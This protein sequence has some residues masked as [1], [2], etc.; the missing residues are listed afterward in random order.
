MGEATE[1]TDAQ[2]DYMLERFDKTDSKLQRRIVADAFARLSNA[3]DERDRLADCLKR[4][5]S[6]MEEAERKLYLQLGDLEAE[7]DRLQ[8]R[9][10]ELERD[11]EISDRWAREHRC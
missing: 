9:V 5:N 4:A 8:S 3:E 2:V 7:R 1:L 6:N 11:K 10:T